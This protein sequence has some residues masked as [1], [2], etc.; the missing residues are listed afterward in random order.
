M[1]LYIGTSGYEYEDWKQHFYPK[2]INHLTYYSRFFNV[3]EINS[4][5]YK[6]PQENTVAK[7]YQETPHNFK[8][9]V[10]MNSYITHYKKLKNV[11]K[12]V[13]KFLLSLSP[14]KEKLSCILFQ[15]SNK[16]KLNEKNMKKLVRLNTFLLHSI[17]YAFEFRDISWHHSKIYALFKKMKWIFVIPFGSIANI[18]Q[19]LLE[20]DILYLRLHGTIELYKGLYTTKDLQKIKQ[21]INNSK[22][23]E[24]YIFF[25]NTDSFSNTIYPDPITNA[26]QTIQLLD[27]M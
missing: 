10:K 7:W 26:F 14:L 18:Q 5:F 8:F 2:N 4:T 17:K 15:F 13:Q 9:V 21:W 12:E 27:G 24:C 6:I 11:R 19:E 16:F 25:N 22:A 23:K 1:R 20:Q 3:V